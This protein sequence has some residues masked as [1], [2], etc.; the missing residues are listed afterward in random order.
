MVN[1]VYCPFSKYDMDELLPLCERYVQNL[2]ICATIFYLSFPNLI[3]YF[4]NLIINIHFIFKD[5]L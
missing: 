4:K 5:C 3:V 2:L 1:C